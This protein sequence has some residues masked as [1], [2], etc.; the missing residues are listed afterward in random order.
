M[1][2]RKAGGRPRGRLARNDVVAS[3]HTSAA[4]SAR[5]LAL[6]KHTSRPPADASALSYPLYSK[7]T[8]PAAMRVTRE[9]QF[10]CNRRSVGP[11]D[12]ARAG[13][14]TLSMPCYVTNKSMLFHCQPWRY[15]CSGIT[16]DNRTQP[17]SLRMFSPCPVTA[18][19]R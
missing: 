10:S 14:A 19:R 18:R 17:L 15:L 11:L 7:C 5:L 16:D 8:R 1:G 9:T 3:F 12:H 6:Y 2:K 4:L 13:C